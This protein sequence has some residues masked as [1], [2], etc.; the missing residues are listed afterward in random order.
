MITNKEYLFELIEKNQAQ[1]F[2]IKEGNNII[3]DCSY[4]PVSVDEVKER[5]DSAISNCMGV[6]IIELRPKSKAE[7]GKGGSTRGTVTLRFNTLAQNANRVA[8]PSEGHSSSGLL[9][10]QKQIEDLKI[11]ALKREFDFKLK[12]MEL[13]RKIEESKG[14]NPMIEQGL[15][16]L[17]TYLAGQNQTAPPVRVGV[18]GV[19]DIPTK[20]RVQSALRRL[21]T[22]DSTW[23]ETLET[24][25]YFAE[26]NPEQY[27]S[28]I[29][30]LKQMYHAQ[31]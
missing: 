18:A 7:L 29:N 23:V 3:D 8:V 5:V 16:F 4:T 1:Y 22:A 20:E 31:K 19:E 9:A 21:K 25:A 6:L 14:N 26:S 15:G 10:M 17:Q 28:N 2:T 27:T 30:L 24:I 13:N 12:E 11:E